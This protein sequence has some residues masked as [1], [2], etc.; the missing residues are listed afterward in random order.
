MVWY[1][2]VWYGMVQ[3]NSSK[4]KNSN[5]RLRPQRLTQQ[6]QE[7]QWYMP[8]TASNGVRRTVI[9]RVAGLGSSGIVTFL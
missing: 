5:T 8:Y 4:N 6:Q 9:G 3:G 2:M 7:R 1:G